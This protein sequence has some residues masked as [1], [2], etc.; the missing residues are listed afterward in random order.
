MECN[1]ELFDTDPSGIAL[2]EAINSHLPPAIR[3]FSVQRVTKSFD[4][5][6]ECTRRVYRYHVPASLLGLKGDG[7]EEDAE[8]LRVLE[9]AWKLFE[10][11]HPFHNYTRRRLYRGP[12]YRGQR[13]NRRSSSN[14][15]GSSNDNGK[16][17]GRRQNIAVEDDEAEDDVDE[18][19]ASDAEE[20]EGE[21][22][23]NSLT[24]SQN[25]GDGGG[26]TEFSPSSSSSS[27]SSETET[28]VATEKEEEQSVE[29]VVVVRPRGQLQL[30]WRAVK[31]E[32]DPVT[33]RHFRN[34][35]E[36]SMSGGL[37]QL[38][39]GGPLCVQLTVKGT[40]FMLHQIRHM[41]GGAVA[42]ALGRIPLDLLDASLGT[43]TR[44]NLPLAPACSLVLAGAEFSPFRTSW[45]GKLAQASATSGEILT[46]TAPG[47][48]MQKGFADQVLLPA[49]SELLASEE[50]GE[51][52]TEVERIWFDE[53][54]AKELVVTYREFR[55]ER[56][57]IRLAKVEAL[58]LEAAAQS[59]ENEE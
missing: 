13:G 48:A 16:G 20:E 57:A 55:R 18:A 58:L 40:S 19:A 7:G 28:A 50:W 54:A 1:P 3:I 6:S 35:D 2:A 36:C 12:A 44:M 53:E 25:N 26:M 56:R 15:S 24:S 10:G 4:A 47:E 46:L 17:G 39:P 23:E 9:Q 43:P 22:V 14:G 30:V 49:V 21:I 52:R 5:R 41:V 51:W 32:A 29:E 59:Y 38:V 42:V 45:D 33:R 31:D 34:I 27:S 8:K 11:N 37:L